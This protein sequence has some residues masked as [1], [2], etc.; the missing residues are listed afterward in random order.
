L[1]EKSTARAESGAEWEGYWDDVRTN[2]LERLIQRYKVRFGYD[3][4]ASSILQRWNGGPILEAG[5]GLA[6]VSRSLL[7][8]AKSAV[9]ALD[10]NFNICRQSRNRPPGGDIRFVQGDVSHLPFKNDTFEM[11]LSTGLLEHFNF[12][13][14]K[15]ILA[16]MR[17]VSPVVVANLPQKAPFWEMNWRLRRRLGAKLDPEQRLYTPKEMVNLFK[18]V[19]FWRI[20]VKSIRFGFLFPYMTLIAER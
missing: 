1:G 15:S 10:Y 7:P 9:V 3:Q 19:G 4:F 11:T 2:F 18:W 17:R 16:E 13:D 12:E 8:Q 14:L 6:F 20:E 5:A